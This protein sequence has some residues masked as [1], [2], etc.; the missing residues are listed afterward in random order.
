MTF[1]ITAAQVRT[2]AARRIAFA[3]GGLPL[4]V[5][6]G[7]TAVVFSPSLA[8]VAVLCAFFSYACLTIAQRQRRA[9]AAATDWE[10]ALEGDQLT[11]PAEK[12]R[13]VLSA[14]DRA[15]YVRLM[16][17]HARAAAFWFDN[18]RDPSAFVDLPLPRAD[19]AALHLSLKAGHVPIRHESSGF[20]ALALVGMLV[21]SLSGLVIARVA[22]RLSAAA[23]LVAPA[24]YVLAAVAVGI[25]IWTWRK[26]S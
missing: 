21:L 10:F 9:A 5:I 16:S 15:D 22:L 11:L 24:T 7:V 12:P 1:T 23:I 17:T 14:I 19:R 8:I 26:T 3:L 20:R 2:L 25:V 6:G 18:R 13:R 4:L